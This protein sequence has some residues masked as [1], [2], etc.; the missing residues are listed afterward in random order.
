MRIVLA[1]LIA[2]TLAACSEGGGSAADGTPVRTDHVELPK[3]YKFD[4]AAIEV[5]AGTAVTWTNHDDF[6]HNVSLLDDSGVSQDVSIGESVTITFDEPGEVPY[7]CS[8]HP[9][10]MQGRVVVV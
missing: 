7:E 9:Q 2:V 1:L 3:S 5:D 6:P 8:F 10:Q 4:P